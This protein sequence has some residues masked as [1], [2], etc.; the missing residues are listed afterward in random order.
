MKLT[1]FFTTAVGVVLAQNLSGQPPCAVCLIIAPF[2]RVYPSKSNAEPLNLTVDLRPPA[3]SQLSARRAVRPMMP[4]ASAD[5]LRRSSLAKSPDVSSRLVHL[6]ATSV[7]R[8][9]P[10]KPFVPL[11]ALQQLLVQQAQQPARPRAPLPSAHLWA[12]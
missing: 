1:V 10:E 9:A 2:P 5:R 6:L 3:L 4:G 12:T 7:K 11:I 8:R